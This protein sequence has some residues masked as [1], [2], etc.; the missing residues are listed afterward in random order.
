MQKLDSNNHSVFSLNYHLLMV[1]KYRRPV[2]D[3]ALSAYA[4][5][6]FE[7]MC[8][9]YGITLE[10]WNHD[11]DHVHCLFRAKTNTPL[12]KF[13]NA[14]KSASSR[15]LKRDFPEVNERIWNGRVW[16]RSYCLLS[17]GGAPIET[18]RA[19]IESQGK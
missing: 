14:Y 12:A 15:D 17:C 5:S 19:Y 9:A 1:T 13:V 8:P 2:F 6:V 11:S 3:D 4:K 10:E 16:S 7:R 18:I